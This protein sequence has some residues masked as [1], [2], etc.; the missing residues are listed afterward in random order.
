MVDASLAPAGLG[1]APFET[2]PVTVEVEVEATGTSAAILEIVVVIVKCQQ[3]RSVIQL[4]RTLA[5]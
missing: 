4:L 5:H 2:V 3:S 1:T